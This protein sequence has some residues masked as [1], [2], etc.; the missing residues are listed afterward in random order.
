MARTTPRRATCNCVSG[1]TIDLAVAHVDGAALG[2][3]GEVGAD[4]AQLRIGAEGV[5]A[6]HRQVEAA[7]ERAHELVA[8]AAGRIDGRGVVGDDLGQLGVERAHV[9][10]DGGDAALDELGREVEAGGVLIAHLAARTVAGRAVGARGA[11]VALDR[12]LVGRHGRQLNERRLQLLEARRGAVKRRLHLADGAFRR[13]RG[14]GAAFQH[15]PVE[16]EAE[17]DGDD[18]QENVAEQYE[19]RVNQS[20]GE[21]IWS[22]SQTTMVISMATEKPMISLWT[23]GSEPMLDSISSSMPT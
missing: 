20:T 14:L 19:R 13:A 1:Q 8:R 23:S 22:S 16:A 17:P 11:L 3:V 15:L 10:F 9:A 21:N 2:A 5:E 6:R 7:A 4:L 12:R 18:R